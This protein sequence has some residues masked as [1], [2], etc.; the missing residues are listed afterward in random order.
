MT[1]SRFLILAAFGVLTA[2]A[3]AAQDRAE[4][5][6]DAPVEHA[7]NGQTGTETE[8]PR[9]EFD[10]LLRERDRSV[11]EL[12]RLDARAARLLR[13]GRD[14]AVVHAEQISV[15]DRLDLVRL[16]LE[17]MAA[18]HGFPLRPAPSETGTVTEDD[19]VLIRATDDAFARGRERALVRMHEDN[20]RFLASIDFSGFL[21]PVRLASTE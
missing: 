18:R 19:P 8:D 7:D 20:I 16:R 11:I 5:M 4:A 10:R 15:Q 21:P 2:P 3:L 12:R 13:D 9:V 14:A 17:L 6:P 1:C